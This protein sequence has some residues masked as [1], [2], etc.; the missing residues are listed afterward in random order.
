VT[1]KT[2]FNKIDTWF[3]PFLGEQVFKELHS[4]TECIVTCGFGGT[5]GGVVRVGGGGGGCRRIFVVFD[6]FSS[7][8]VDRTAG[9]TSL[10]ASSSSQLS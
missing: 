9:Q 2:K 1:K 4:R 5:I 7:K 10:S 8:F 3:E 6:A